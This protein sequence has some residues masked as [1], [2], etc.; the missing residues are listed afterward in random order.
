VRERGSHT[1]CG[2]L[3]RL[4]CPTDKQQNPLGD[5]SYPCS[6]KGTQSGAFAYFIIPSVTKMLQ[7]QKRKNK[8]QIFSAFCF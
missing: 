3:R 1:A 4:A 6:F 2:I 7:I 8:M 5:N